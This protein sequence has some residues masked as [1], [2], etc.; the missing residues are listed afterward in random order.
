MGRDEALGALGELQRAEEQAQATPLRGLQR[1]GIER[2][3]ETLQQGFRDLQLGPITQQLGQEDIG[4]LE[5]SL[6][7]RTLLNLFS[8]EP[9]RADLQE[10]GVGGSLIDATERGR[11]FVSEF[12]DGELRIF[13]PPGEAPVLV[14]RRTPDEPFGFLDPPPGSGIEDLPGDVADVVGAEGLQLA[15]EVGGA[16]A[17]GALTGGT[18]VVPNGVRALGR[19]IA[20]Q[21]AGVLARGAARATEAGLTASTAA[22]LEATGAIVGE[23]ARQGFQGL[24]GGAES[25]TPGEVGVAGVEGGLGGGAGELVPIIFRGAGRLARERLEP[26]GVG[27]APARARAADVAQREGVDLTLGQTEPGGVLAKVESLASFFSRPLQ[28][29]YARQRSVG[30]QML[31]RE[32]QRLDAASLIDEVRNVAEET[33]RAATQSLAELLR[34]PDARAIGADELGNLTDRL[35]REHD[36]EMRTMV[37]AVY[38]DLR[39]QLG[40][41][42]FFETDGL[43]AQLD[44]LAERLSIGQ[45]G[46]PAE[47]SGLVDEAGRPIPSTQPAEFEDVLPVEA[48]ALLARLGRGPGQV[49]RATFDQL[50]RLRTSIQELTLPDPRTGIVRAD[51]SAVQPTLDFLNRTLDDPVGP[52]TEAQRQ[53]LAGARQLAQQ[54]FDGVEVRRDIGLVLRPDRLNN[55]RAFELGRSLTGPG[56]V[57]RLRALEEVPGA[58]DAAHD[59]FVSAAILNPAEGS[60]LVDELDV[61]TRDLLLR[62]DDVRIREALEQYDDLIPFVRQLLDREDVAGPFEDAIARGSSADTSRLLRSIEFNGGPTGELGQAT[63]GGVFAHVMRE[64]SSYDPAT[65][66][67]EVN[68]DA[69]SRVIRDL[70]ERGVSRLITP[71]QRELLSDVEAFTDAVQLVSD[72]SRSLIGGATVAGA[73]GGAGT[74]LTRLGAF[75][76]IGSVLASP[77][78]ARALRQ[79][80]EEG[81]ERIWPDLASQL[82]GAWAASI[83]ASAEAQEIY[84]NRPPLS[85][86]VDP[87]QVSRPATTTTIGAPAAGPS[88]SELAEIGRA[89][90]AR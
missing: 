32:V 53:Q 27:T 57:S 69:L 60:R 73:V 22:A 4:S 23:G 66:S 75:H 43:T 25:F 62:G 58:L 59:G 5:L 16:L 15:G 36:A 33:E 45:R 39:Q 17:F 46:V 11:A 30:R 50:L 20:P 90:L 38:D 72:S 84:L 44:D 41:D 79:I 78:T 40:R 82:L 65:Q 89:A 8:D 54:R 64:S 14:G 18:S 31:E 10:A 3:F 76:L 28:R 24:V 52:L 29:L 87:E 83:T 68:A 47:A 56:A 70:D 51:Q 61:E 71:E 6:P 80:A 55:P 67:W 48:R 63:Q 37:G 77:M 49:D 42:V 2:R 21:G 74:N 81:R 86:A 35:L 9:T 85:G 7:Q 13:L 19:R 26:G 88:G 1:R 34:S 12:P